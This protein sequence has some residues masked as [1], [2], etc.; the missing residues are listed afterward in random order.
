MTQPVTTATFGV[1]QSDS[2]AP[3]PE[4]LKRLR[5][6]L[7]GFAKKIEETRIRKGHTPVSKMQP[8]KVCKVCGKGFDFKIIKGSPFPELALCTRCTALLDEGYQAIIAD[9]RYAFVKSAELA[10]GGD[11]IIE[12]SPLVFDKLQATF[13]LEWAKK[14]PVILTNENPPESNSPTN[15]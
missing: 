1:V 3:D 7:P 9:N 13:K 8:A 4:T 2:N 15:N 6:S 10:K 5:E 11:Q 12:C 14:E